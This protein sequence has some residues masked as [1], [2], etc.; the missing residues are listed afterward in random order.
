MH[1]AFLYKKY[2]DS[3]DAPIADNEDL[4]GSGEF[5]VDI[6]YE[7]IGGANFFIKMIVLQDLI[8]ILKTKGWELFTANME[9]C[10]KPKEKISPFYFDQKHNTVSF[11]LIKKPK[12]AK[13]K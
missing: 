11:I 12:V 1:A 6:P 4:D 3:A 7:E 5:E 8:S 2:L 13:S 9:W 10:C